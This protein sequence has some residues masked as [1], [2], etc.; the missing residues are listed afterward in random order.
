MIALAEYEGGVCSCGFHSSLTD[1][2]AN[3]FTFETKVCTVCAGWSKMHR[4]QESQDSRADEMLGEKPPPNATRAADGRK[5]FMRMMSADEVDERRGAR[6]VPQQ[7]PRD[8]N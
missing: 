5:T 2:R 3:F 6:S 7:S 1:D 8:Q 4:I